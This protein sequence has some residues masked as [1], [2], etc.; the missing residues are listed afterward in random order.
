MS[1]HYVTNSWVEGATTNRFANHISL[2]FSENGQK[3]RNCAWDLYKAT[4]AVEDD[5]GKKKYPWLF[6]GTPKNNQ[7]SI[8]WSRT[9]T[10]VQKHSALS[11]M[12]LLWVGR[13]SQDFYVDQKTNYFYQL[14][15]ED[16]FSAV[17]VNRSCC[18]KSG[19]YKTRL[20]ILPFSPFPHYLK[21]LVLDL[22]ISFEFLHILAITAMFD[23]K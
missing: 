5:K 18:I 1:V 23:I 3:A 2:D 14:Q 6:G 4:E 17:L 22:C 21:E 20:C 10:D 13:N 15:Q 7:Y 11:L 8:F 12:P 19:G 9:C 16:L